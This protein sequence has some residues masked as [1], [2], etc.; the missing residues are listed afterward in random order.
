LETKFH[1]KRAATKNFVPGD[2][3]FLPGQQNRNE[4]MQLLGMGVQLTD[5][6]FAQKRGEKGI[7]L[8]SD[9]YFWTRGGMNI[10][11]IDFLWNPDQ[12][13]AGSDKWN[14]T[15]N[16]REA[17]QAAGTWWP[18]YGRARPISPADNVTTT[19]L[20]VNPNGTYFTPQFQPPAYLPQAYTPPPQQTFFNTGGPQNTDYSQTASAQRYASRGTRFEDQERWVPGEGYVKIGKLIKQGRLDVKTGKFSETPMRKNEATEHW[21]KWGDR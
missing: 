20:P 7:V 12:Y 1:A 21:L 19:G 17:A 18:T 2:L 10:P 8:P 6:Y 13:P 9:P 3:E 11:G 15:A 4:M 16:Q 14:T 5:N